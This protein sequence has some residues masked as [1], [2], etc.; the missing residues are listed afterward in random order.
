MD[1]KITKKGKYMQYFIEP[2]YVWSK[3]LKG[4]PIRLDLVLVYDLSKLK[5]VVHKYHGRTD[6]KKDGFVFRDKE[7]KKQALLGIIKIL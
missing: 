4:K 3:K 1:F 5:R 6:I 2:F 7:N